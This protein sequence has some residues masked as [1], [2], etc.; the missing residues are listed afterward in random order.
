MWLDEIAA[1]AARAKDAVSVAAV[2]VT[3]TG[4]NDEYVRS[5]PSRSMPP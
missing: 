4:D 2:V 1:L 3:A 5:L